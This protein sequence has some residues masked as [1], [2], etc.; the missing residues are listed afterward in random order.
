MTVLT[1]AIKKNHDAAGWSLTCVS[2]L[3]YQFCYKLKTVY[4]VLD[5]LSSMLLDI[6]SEQY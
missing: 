6:P 5:V 1:L 3:H 2:C 4:C